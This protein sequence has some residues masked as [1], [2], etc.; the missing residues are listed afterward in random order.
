MFSDLGMKGC[1]SNSRVSTKSRIGLSGG[2][3]STW[4]PN[5]PICPVIPTSPEATGRCALTNV[6]LVR[7]S[8]RRRSISI[9]DI[10]NCGS[11]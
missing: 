2:I 4:I 10:T 1:L 9:S 3:H 8:P 7:R 5:L 6:L 11:I